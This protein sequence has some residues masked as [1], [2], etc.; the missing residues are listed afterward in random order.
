MGEQGGGDQGRG[1]ARDHRCQLIAKRGAAVAQARR[2]RLRDQ[3]RLWPVLHVV[4][5]QRQHDRDEHRR[6]YRGVHHAEIEEPEQPDRSGADQV[7]LLAADA[8]GDMAGQRDADQRDASRDHYCT[9]DQVAR[10]MQSADGIGED[11]G[12]EDVERGLLRHPQQRR[13]DD[14]L[15]LSLDDFD[16]RSPLDSLVIEKLLEHRRLKDAETNP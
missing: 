14:F 7:H 6:G 2:E 10:H 12:G 9:Q 3:R 8:I 11:K 16:N 4:R 15:R 5:D 1:S 13:Q